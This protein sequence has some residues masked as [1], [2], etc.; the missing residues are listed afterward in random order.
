MVRNGKPTGTAASMPIGVAAGVGVAVLLLLAGS[1]LAAWLMQSGNM[2]ED[3]IGYGAMTI[4]LVSS[5]A[6]VWTAMRV[7][8]HNALVVGLSTAAA[9][10]ILLLGMTAIFFGGQYQGIIPTGIMIFGGSIGAVLVGNRAG[11]NRIPRRHKTR[12][13]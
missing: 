6:G 1:A 12:T 4:L 7:V 5:I 11:G 9:Y 3:G 2:K 8:K 10:F 13:G